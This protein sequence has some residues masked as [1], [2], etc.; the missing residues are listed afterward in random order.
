MVRALDM[1]PAAMRI[2]AMCTEFEKSMAWERGGIQC[3][4]TLDMCGPGVLAELKSCESRRIH[5]M[6]FQRQARWYKYPEQISWYAVGNGTVL[7]G[8]TTPW[9]D[10]YIISVESKAPHDVVVHHCGNLLLDQANANIEQWLITY[11]ACKAD[12]NWPGHAIDVVEFDAEVEF[13]PGDAD[14]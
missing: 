1:H 2:K 13:G 11:K 9:P 8:S 7:R 14:D 5:P 10:S 3:G 4:G 12:N 6:A